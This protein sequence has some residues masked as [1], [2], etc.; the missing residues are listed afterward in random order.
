MP[1]IRC[2]TYAAPAAAALA[3]SQSVEVNK[4]I[5]KCRYV[6][7]LNQV[8]SH[9]EPPA[10]EQQVADVPIGVPR[11]GP[12]RGITLDD[13]DFLTNSASEAYVPIIKT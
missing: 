5:S 7:L 2:E 9:V 13:A 1:Q 3:V 12:H 4:N 8:R 11:Q 10:I 6:C